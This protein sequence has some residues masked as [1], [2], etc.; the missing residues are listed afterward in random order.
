MDVFVMGNP[1]KLEVKVKTYFYKNTKIM[2]RLK[3]SLACLS[4]TITTL[5]ISAVMFPKV[6]ASPVQHKTTQTA[7]NWFLQGIQK[8]NQQDFQG[9]LSDFTQAISLNSQYAE[10]YYQRGLIYAKYAQGKPLNPDG[11]VPGCRK[12]DNYRI[13]CPVKVKDRI[14]EY[15][16]KAIA[17]F[18]QTIQLNPQYAAAYHQRALVEDESQKQSQDF[19]VCINLYFQKSLVY[20][21]QKN[22][23]QA[24]D[25]LE[26]INKIHVEKK[27]LARLSLVENRETNENPLNSS[28]ISPERR[29]SPDVLMSEARQDVRKGNLRAAG[30]KYR[31]AALLLKERKDP[32]YQEVQQII[33]ALEQ[34]ANK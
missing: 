5:S 13:I 17:D 29:K 30:Q 33:A 26:T 9:A 31:E 7:N 21:N 23:K 18:T 28:T 22:Y 2:F 27:A 19:Q 15:K 10:A 12:I 16:Q 14:K 11:T 4:L 6:E 3:L 25:L 34:I 20:L 1:F 24:A 8:A 32:R